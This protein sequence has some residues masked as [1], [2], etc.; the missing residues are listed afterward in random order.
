VGAAGDLKVGIFFNARRAQGG[1]FAYA[2]T[3][4]DCLHRF[5][6]HSYC[7]VRA[8]S[9]PMPPTPPSD[10]WT[11]VAPRRLA[12][13]GR[14][15]VEV[16]LLSVA[17]LGWRY[18]LRVLP[19]LR[20][21]RKTEVDVV[22]Y[23]KPTMH[24]FMWNTPAVFP[25]HDLQHRLQ[26]QFREV[27]S[28]GEYLRREFL[29]RNAI[30]CGAE[31]LV[32]SAVGREDVLG[33]YPAAAPER[34]HVLP[35][36][37]PTYLPTQVGEGDQ[38]RVRAKYDARGRFLFYPAIFWRHKNH[39]NLLRALAAV[40]ARHG[41]SV[42]LLLAG[43]RTREYPQV[44]SLAHQLGLQDDVRFLGYVPDEDL[45]PLYSLARALTM[46]TFFGPTNI[47]VLE[48]WSFGCPVITSDVRGVREQVGDAGLL[49]S[50]T[51]VEAMATAIWRVW[52]DDDL[53]QS[54]RVKGRERVATWT[55]QAF[56]RELDA[57]LLKAAGRR[58][59]VLG[60]G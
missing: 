20:P 59:R 16:A 24:P 22:L 4:V 17:R 55:P 18:P 46:P 45:Y 36:L 30:R 60:T 2:L 19:E 58:A 28:R 21:L 43:S 48:A 11:T 25:I 3:L 13:L 44:V 32:D 47:P 14:R 51:D 53:A 23:V 9:E 54:L 6:R 7:L 5:G 38:E 50:P 40:K 12:V 34:V 1:L 49:V 39:A 35:Y 26:R 27:S 37:A 15:A 41:Q 33:C 31:I 56:A 29:Y 52:T 57:V 10:R 8:T 42:R